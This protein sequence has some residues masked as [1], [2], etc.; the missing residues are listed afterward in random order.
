MICELEKKR[1][2]ELGPTNVLP[3]TPFWGRIKN[4]Q[5]YE[6]RG[7]ELSVSKDLLYNSEK[8]LIKF[9]D[10]I[11]VLIKRVNR[12]ECYAYIPYGPELEPVFENQGVFLEEIS[13]VI[14]PYLP[15]GCIFIRYDLMWQNQ[16]A[17]EDEY[18]DRSGNWL[19]P[20][21]KKV[22]EF[23]VNYKTSKWNLK[24]SPGDILPKNT[25]FLDLTK[26]EKDLLYNM[27][28]NTRYNIKKAIKKGVKIKEYGVGDI[29][30]WYKLYV[31]TAVR[32]GM[33]L[34]SEEYFA[35]V[36]KNQDNGKNGVS[37]KML[38]ADYRGELLASMF[39]V[40]SNKR[41]TY[42]YGASTENRK[43]LMASYALQWNAIKIAKKSGCTEYDMFGSAP[44]LNN[45]HPLHGVHIY[46]KGFGG[47]LYHRMGCWDYPYQQ[48][49]YDLFKFHEISSLRN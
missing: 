27:R 22:Q 7:F 25:F 6:P 16:W 35:S 11:L 23:R 37:V 2:D 5:G 45:S 33:P 29:G 41:G 17:V 40:L 43:N 8:N 38:M 20:P 3:Q 14:R 18:F 15:E 1:I 10:N 24:K 48:K 26:K 12:D 28:Y 49:K 13:E 4:E 21:E 9:N 44:N 36:L 19:G 31:E 47:N 39:L 32:H 46:K 34:Q 42:L 30:S